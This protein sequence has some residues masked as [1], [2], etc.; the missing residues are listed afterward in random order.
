MSISRFARA[1]AAY[2]EEI[3]VQW[4][5]WCAYL[6]LHL[7]LL[8]IRAAAEGRPAFER[9]EAPDDAAARVRADLA[10]IPANRRALFERVYEMRRQRTQAEMEAEARL[11][12]AGQMRPLDPDQV[13][14]RTLETLLAEAEGRGSDD[15]WGLVP[16]DDDEWYRVDVAALEAAPSAAAYA[17]DRSE[18]DDR[19]RRVR[20]LAGLVGAAL[21]LLVVWL[22]LA[23][24]TPALSTVDA[25]TVNGT[26]A[27]IW[28]PTTLTL[29]DQQGVSTTLMVREATTWPET[30]TADVALWRRDRVWPLTFCISGALLADVA[31]ARIESTGAAPA[32]VYVLSDAATKPADLALEMCGAGHDPHMRYGVLQ[33]TESLAT[34]NPGEQFR[35]NDDHLI[36][37]Q[38]IT[39]V[40]S[41]QD[42]TVPPD[43]AR[44]VLTVNAPA[45][46]DWPAYAPTL[47]LA[48]G[49]EL[50]PSVVEPASDVASLTYLIPL[51]KSPIEAAWS[52]TTPEKRH[53]R[54]RF[55]LIPP[56]SRDVVLQAAL[57]VDAVTATNDGVDGLQ[58]HVTLHNRG[59][60]PLMLTRADLGLTQGETPLGFI[61]VADLDPPLVSSEMRTISLSVVSGRTAQPLV[62]RVGHERFRIDRDS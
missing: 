52:V 30:G 6:R 19:Q 46:L 31:L 50:L 34:V 4:R 3:T 22:L 60:Q 38:T 62:L 5:D 56:L 2:Q 43:Q 54:W 28:T 13:D 1:D 59:E 37:L 23:P 25:I 7:A 18:A 12:S 21:L 45:T 16:I 41:S 47:L 39:L 58:I 48:T 42:A 35:L 53:V 8:D 11:R 24:R 26:P 49:Q 44:V 27:P 15:G 55:D 29:T 14:R 51:P 57:V 33:S 61:D 40:G 36:R 17:A 32:R 10:A 9:D 20:M